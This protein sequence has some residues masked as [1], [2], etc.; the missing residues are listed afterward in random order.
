MTLADTDDENQD[1]AGKAR[2]GL[3]ERS[4][5]IIPDLVSHCTIPVRCNRHNKQASVESKRW[6]AALSVAG[7]GPSSVESFTSSV[8]FQCFWLAAIL[9]VLTSMSLA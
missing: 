1:K 7:L 3:S 4:K 8:L 2:L 9:A 5:I 6:S